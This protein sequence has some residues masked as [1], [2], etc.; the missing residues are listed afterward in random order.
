V[1]VA[2]GVQAGILS[3]G[4]I[5]VRTQSSLAHIGAWSELRCMATTRQWRKWEEQDKAHQ[6]LER[7]LGIVKAA[8]SIDEAIAGLPGNSPRST[9]PGGQ[10]YSNAIF[11]LSS[12]IVPSGAGTP[13]LS[14]YW[15]LV[16]RLHETG[17]IDDWKFAS[18]AKDFRSHAPWLFDGAIE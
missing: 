14:A 5:S 10:Y 8:N 7:V 2:G 9:S 18:I 13:E 3:K 16:Q 12:L 17:Q 11:F 4:L 1:D 15:G 6:H